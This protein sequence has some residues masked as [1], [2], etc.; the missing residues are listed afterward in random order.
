M[1]NAAVA[2]IMSQLGCSTFRETAFSVSRE[3]VE[4]RGVHR[5]ICLSATNS[6]LQ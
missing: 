5:I 2:L 4:Q 6:L 3:R 1:K